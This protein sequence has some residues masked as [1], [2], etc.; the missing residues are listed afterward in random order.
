MGTQ[1]ARGPGIRGAWS[2][3][4]LWGCEEWGVG[5]GGCGAWGV[6]GAGRGARGSGGAGGR[7]SV[8]VGVGGGL[9]REL[10]H[11]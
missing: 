4:T 10:G 7:E 6:G 9:W 11:R 5:S 3:K 1:R 2:R 8:G